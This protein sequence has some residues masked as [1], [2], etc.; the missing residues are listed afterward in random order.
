MRGTKATFGRKLNGK[1]TH[2]KP[3]RGRGALPLGIND[4]NGPCG[5]L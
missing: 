5:A 1:I 2:D 4:P 3:T